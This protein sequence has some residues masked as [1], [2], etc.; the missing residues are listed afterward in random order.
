[1]Y[2]IIFEK[3][4]SRRKVEDG[5]TYSQPDEVVWHGGVVQEEPPKQHEGHNERGRQ[6]HGH[7]VGAGQRGDKVPETHRRVGE[8]DDDAAGDEEG[9]HV[10]VH[11]RHPV[12]DGDKDHRKNEEGRHVH[13]H[14][15]E[16]VDVHAVHAVKVF[17]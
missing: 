1:M 15:A 5:A 14:L 8:E 9:A 13:Q 6:R 17:A 7:V 10:C 2:V 4:P 3:N 16:I 11:A 12:G